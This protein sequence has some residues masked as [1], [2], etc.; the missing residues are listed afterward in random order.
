MKKIKYLGGGWTQDPLQ[1]PQNPQDCNKGVYYQLTVGKVYDV[2]REDRHYFFQDDNGE[3]LY[4][5]K[6]FFEVVPDTIKGYKATYN[7]KCRNQA[8]VVGKTYTSDILEMCSHGFHYCDK[9]EDTL[10]Y[11]N[12]SDAFILLEVEI[13]GEVISRSDKSVTNKLKVLRV[14]PVEEY[15]DTMKLRLKVYEW[16]DRGNMISETF[17]NG[18]KFTYEYDDRNNKISET[19]PNGGK[20]IYEYDD[21]GN[22]ISETYPSGNKYTYEYDDRNNLIAKIYPNGSKYTYEYDDRNNKI[23]ETYP[24]GSKYTYEYDDRGKMISV[25]FPSGDKF[26]YEYDDRNNRVAKTYPSGHTE[27]TT[28]ATI[29]EE[30]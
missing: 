21:R 3:Y 14:V 24:S 27:F 4:E 29:T 1:N 17:P 18:D 26:T 8:Y 6:E 12:H 7:F 23:S 2:S 20:H 11:Y 10:E 16:D 13:L 9:M 15:S 30:D 28:Y 22:M 19:F 5:E 25:T